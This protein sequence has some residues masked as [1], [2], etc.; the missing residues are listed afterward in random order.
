MRSRITW[1]LPLFLLSFLPNQLHAQARFAIYGT[2]G[3]ETGGVPNESWAL[4]GTAGF[5]AGLK[6]LGPLNFSLDARADLSSDVSSGLIGPRLAIKLPA[7]PIKPYGEFLIG[8]S[9]FS[10][11]GG[12]KDSNSFA[13]RYV[14]GADM[15]ILPH[16]DWRIAD[17]SYDLNDDDG[18]G[19]AKTLSTGLVLRY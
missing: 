12:L 11:S 15:T 7:F 17:F 14:L 6:K 10:G 1:A 16:I 9:D 8:F 2:V 3:G 13:A 18:R 4:A 19:N 5:Y